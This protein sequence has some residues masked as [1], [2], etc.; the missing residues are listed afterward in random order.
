MIPRRARPRE[1]RTKTDPRVALAR[2]LIAWGAP[3]S[4]VQAALQGATIDDINNMRKE[5]EHEP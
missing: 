3:V 4:E 5:A 2:S 1:R